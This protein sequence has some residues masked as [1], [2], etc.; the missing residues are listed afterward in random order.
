MK[1]WLKRILI[2][3]L[4]L[5]VGSWLTGSWLLKSW[6][7][8]PPPLPADVKILQLKPQVREGKIWVGQSWLGHREGLLVLLLKGTPFEM[9]YADASLLQTQIHTLENEFLEMVHG[10]VPHEWALNL[11]KNYVIYRNR[12]LSEHVPLDF[13]MEILGGTLGCPDI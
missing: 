13:R 5:S 12:H 2:C 4:G 3:G 11:L 10:Y 8:K 7:A 6:M 9:G 1:K